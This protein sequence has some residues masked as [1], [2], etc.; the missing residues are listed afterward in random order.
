[1]IW[2]PEKSQGEGGGV[3]LQETWNAIRLRLPMVNW[4]E[5]LYCMLNLS[6]STAICSIARLAIRNKLLTRDK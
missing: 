3:Q 4:Y 2:K 6:P 1:M 5:T